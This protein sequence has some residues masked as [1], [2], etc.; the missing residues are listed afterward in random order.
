MARA[1]SSLPVPLSPWISTVL[2]RLETSRARSRISCMRAFLLITSCTR[3]LP[4][5]LLAQDGVLALQ[6][7]DFDDAVHQQ[8]D[9]LRIAGLDDVLLRALL[10]GRDGRIHRGVSRDDDDR[11]L[12]VHAADLHHGLDAVHAAGHLQIDEIDGIV[13]L[14]G[15]FHGLAPGGGRIHQVAILA[16]PG[17]QRFAHH[18]FVVH[19]QDL[20]VGFHNCSLA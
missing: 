9:L 2:R 20:P 6:V 15:L 16:Q 5:E 13:L 18:F 10:H 19:H 7:L 4:R 8:R 11:G 17:G 3:V 12:G 14:A 1:I